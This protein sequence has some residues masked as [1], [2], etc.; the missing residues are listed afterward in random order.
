[1]I[2]DTLYNYNIIFDELGLLYS[3][4]F[5]H[6]ADL[7]NTLV[8]DYYVIKTEKV[9]ENIRNTSLTNEIE[10]NNSYSSA[11]LI[12]SNV[13]K[14]SLSSSSDRDWYKFTC[15]TSI[16]SGKVDIVLGCPDSNCNFSVYNDSLSIL[17]SGNSFVS[18]YGESGSVAVTRG[19][20]YYICVTPPSGTSVSSS[21]YYYLYCKFKENKTWF[22]QYNANCLGTQYWN[23][24]LLDKLYFT[25]YSET[26]P[27][28]KDAAADLMDSGC[29]CCCLAMLLNNVGAVTRH[30][31]TDFRTNYYGSMYADP[32][33]I[34]LSNC[35]ITTAPTRDGSVYKY[36]KDIHGIN[37][38]E[39]SIRKL[40]ADADRTSMQIIC[41]DFDR[42]INNVSVSTME[43]VR[44]YVSSNPEGV[45]VKLTASGNT[46]WIVLVSANNSDGFVVYDP[47]SQYNTTGNGVPFSSSCSAQTLGYTL[48][49][50]TTLY[51]IT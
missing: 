21:D 6:G 47:A 13:I 35:N 41:S 15:P 5:L 38:V 29:A 46:H 25:D 39:L 31:L 27:F 3:G 7:E 11:Q 24:Y 12:S 20:T 19:K 32:F 44:S 22:S 18:G 8:F 28:S 23:N 42:T 30:K 45:M 1:M 49:D 36:N 48:D 37:P 26:I 4:K 33:I 43:T 17:A 10:S 50:I 16:P 40:L 51:Y 9:N 34:A 14:G 2:C